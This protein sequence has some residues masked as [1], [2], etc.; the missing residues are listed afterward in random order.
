MAKTI[1]GRIGNAW[2]EKS[3]WIKVQLSK[4]IDRLVLG[5]KNRGEQP[6]FIA[7]DR[8]EVIELRDTLNKW[9]INTHIANC[10]GEL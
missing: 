5:T 4:E 6:S 8:N 9:L 1:Y 10:T 7:L 2:G 3:C